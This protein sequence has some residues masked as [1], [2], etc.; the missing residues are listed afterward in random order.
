MRLRLVVLMQAGR[1]EA[2]ICLRLSL[3]GVV[4]RRRLRAPTLLV[5]RARRAA[6]VVGG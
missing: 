2:L 4:V 5:S 3:I 1:E 6:S